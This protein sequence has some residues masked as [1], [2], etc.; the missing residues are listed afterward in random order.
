MALGYFTDATP[1]TPLRDPFNVLVDEINGNAALVSDTLQNYNYRWANAAART[2]QA[3]MRAGDLGY[4]VDTTITYRYDGS[5]WKYWASPKITFTPTLTNIAVGTGGSARNV[6][7][8]TIAAG[9]CFVHGDLALGT[10]GASVSGA[11]QISVPLPGNN[12]LS[13]PANSGIG[14]P[15]GTAKILDIGVQHYS[16]VAETASQSGTLVVEIRPLLASG[17]YVNPTTTSSTVPMTWSGAGSSDL[18]A[19]DYSYVLD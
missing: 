7:Y 8:Y 1:L 3:G 2:G 6:A 13:G 9:R 14:Q 19:Y 16:A 4:Q 5:S 10:S 18:I 17:T 11:I 12:V 15:M